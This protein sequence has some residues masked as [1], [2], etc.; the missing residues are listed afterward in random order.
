M[1]VARH[2]FTTKST[3]YT[4]QLK[5]ML[6]ATGTG[7][8]TCEICGETKSLN[9]LHY[10]LNESMDSIVKQV[11]T[12]LKEDSRKGDFVSLV[13]SDKEDFE[14][15]CTDEEIKTMSRHTWKQ[16]IKKKTKRFALKYLLEENSSKE[17]TK[18]VMF[19]EYKIS[20]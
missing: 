16:F 12:A 18:S 20:D 10:I 1:K 2:C 19:S 7:N 6:F 11:Y 13:N 4:W 14:I 17:K 9:F 15:D 5:H 3:V 8:Y